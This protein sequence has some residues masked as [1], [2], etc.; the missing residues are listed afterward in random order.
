MENQ[1][2][3]A[4]EL[5]KEAELVILP[6]ET[7]YGIFAD[8]MNQTA[9][10]KL[11]AA[12]GRPTGKA[13]NLNVANFT[14]ILKFSQNQPAY[15][16]KLVKAF[17]PGPLTII[18]E[19]SE[20]VPEWVH[21]GKQT[22]GFRMPAVELAQAVIREVGVLVGPSANLTGQ[23]SPVRFSDLSPE[24]LAKAALALEDESI[25]GLDTTIL[26]LT[27][28]PARILRQGAISSEEILEEV[29]EIQ[30]IE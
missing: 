18:L 7:V 23:A 17:L 19:A 16:E 27:V 25:S 3:K 20:V 13:L 2:T 9:V 12:K 11:Y 21:I 5:L 22:V 4:V 29:P 8:A 15:L 24:I 10:E 30:I 1:I 28:I 26:D 6:T 14:T